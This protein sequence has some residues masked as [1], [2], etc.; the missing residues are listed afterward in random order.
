ML[1]AVDGSV[2]TA[3]TTFL[4]EDD[5][6]IVPA[7]GYPRLALLDQDKTV[8]AQY[9]ATPTANPG[10]WISAISLPNLGLEQI[11]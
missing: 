10:E 11:S 6:T 4:D 9:N 8:I 5:S 2:V 7:P 3:T 1:R